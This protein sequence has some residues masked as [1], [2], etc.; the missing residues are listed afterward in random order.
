[1]SAPPRRPLHSTRT[2]S[3]PAL[4][5]DCDGALHGT[6]KSNPVLELVSDA[7]CASKRRI[8]IRILH[9]IDVE[10]DPSVRHLLQLGTETLGLR[11]FT[12][13]Y[14]TGSGGVDVDDETVTSPLDVDARDGASNQVIAKEITDLPSPG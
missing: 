10:L 4:S 2:P 14:N 6:T 11:A 3:A 5:A 13:D 8:E 9:L 12:A 7:R 1:M